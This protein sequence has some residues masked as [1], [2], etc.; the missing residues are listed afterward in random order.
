MLAFVSSEMFAKRNLRV[1][2]IVTMLTVW[3]EATSEKPKLAHHWF[4]IFV[5]TEMASHDRI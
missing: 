3:V 1:K 2:V 5:E 4:R